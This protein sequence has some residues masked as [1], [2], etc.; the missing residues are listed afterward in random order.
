MKFNNF[1]KCYKSFANAV[2]NNKPKE[3]QLIKDKTKSTKTKKPLIQHCKLNAEM[4]D[5][6]EDLNNQLKSI[7]KVI[8]EICSS[9]NKLVS[10]EKKEK[11]LKTLNSNK[12]VEQQKKVELMLKSA[13]RYRSDDNTKISYEDDPMDIDS[14]EAW[15]VLCKYRTKQHSNLNSKKIKKGY[16]Q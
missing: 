13:R 9:N 15:S 16:E 1:G 2:E 7:T 3:K 6:I 11:I 14:V 4:M 8:I 10:S 5:V 12:Y